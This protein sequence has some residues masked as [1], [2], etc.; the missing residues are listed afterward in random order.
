MAHSK[1]SKHPVMFFFRKSWIF[2]R[3]IKEKYT[4]YFQ[5]NRRVSLEAFGKLWVVLGAGFESQ[6][7]NFGKKDRAGVG[8]L[9]S[10][11]GRGRRGSQVHVLDRV[12]SC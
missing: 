10:L 11:L 2:K 7:S 3:L 5:G 1:Y 9:V 8:I 12:Q 6:F 4:G